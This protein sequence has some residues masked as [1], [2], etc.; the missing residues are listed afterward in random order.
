MVCE[1]SRYPATVALS[2]TAETDG[3]ITTLCRSGTAANARQRTDEVRTHVLRVAATLT[4]QLGDGT[5]KA[6][7]GDGSQAGRVCDATR[8]RSPSPD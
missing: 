1:V 5:G 2:P 6:A 7:F 4:K 8:S 3:M